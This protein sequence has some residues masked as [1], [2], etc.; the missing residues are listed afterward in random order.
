M[1]EK[2][3]LIT[4]RL[5]AAG[6]QFDRSFQR[7]AQQSDT[8][9]KLRLEFFDRIA[10]LDGGT[11]ALSVTLLRYLTS[12]S[13]HVLKLPSL[14]ISSWAVFVLSMAFALTRNWIEHNRLSAA[15][16]NNFLLTV[17]ELHDAR[18][19]LGLAVSG[20][21]LEVKRAKQV[22]EEGKTVLNK[23]L[24][25]HQRLLKWTKL[26]GMFS[27]VAS[28]FGFILLLLFAVKNIPY[29]GN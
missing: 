20:E 19:Q 27:L 14:L 16:S 24:E 21:C 5:E 3:Q 2:V 10:L 13:W 23:Q 25:R 15:E 17:N 11:V 1:L 18:I 26:T 8:V 29:F 6:E 7:Q 4:A 28:L 9:A 12:K 22:Q